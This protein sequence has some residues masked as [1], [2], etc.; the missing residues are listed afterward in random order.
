MLSFRIE[1]FILHL[2]FSASQHSASRF[3]RSIDRRGTYATS[4]FTG[5]IVLTAFFYAVESGSMP[6]AVFKP[7]WDPKHI[8]KVWIKS[9]DATSRSTDKPRHARD[10]RFLNE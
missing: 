10:K 7:L 3:F 4:N 8:R 2:Y 9:V 6:L 1:K 5:V